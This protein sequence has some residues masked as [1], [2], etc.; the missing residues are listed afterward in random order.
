MNERGQAMAAKY[1]EGYTMDEIA[2]EHGVS[3]QRV[4]QIIQNSY[5][6][7]HWGKRK[8][9]AL[10]ERRRAAHARI[11]AGESTLDEEAE[12]EGVTTTTL[13]TFFYELGLR[14][15]PPSPRHGTAYRYSRGCRCPE[16]TEAIR[17]QREHWRESR[18]NR[19]PPE[20]GTESGYKNWGCR[21][22][23]CKAAGSESNR[24]WRLARQQ[25]K[26]LNLPEN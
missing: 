19:E 4:H 25:R 9:D 14:L 23:A 18:K 3:R 20:H 17:E 26:L 11:V 12:K 24:R 15:T 16:C 13:Q 21:C 2:R 1:A 22:D 8:K 7:G 10:R 5:E 6:R